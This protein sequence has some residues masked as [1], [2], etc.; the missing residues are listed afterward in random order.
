MTVQWRTLE[1]IAQSKLADV[2][3]LFPLSGLY[4][5]ASTDS[6]A[7]SPDKELAIT[8]ILGTTEW[9]E[10]FYTQPE[11]QDLFDIPHSSQRTATPTQM[12]QYVKNR[13]KTLFPWVSDPLMLHQTSKFGHNG[14]PLFSVFFAIANDAP[15][16]I[17][18]AKRIVTSVQ[19]TAAA[20]SG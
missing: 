7:I 14:A 8:S 16:A 12:N 11:Y 9:K 5:Q 19:K 15:K 10:V 2:W 13:L 20:F 3:Y 1:I 18:L 17:G 6:D 4:R